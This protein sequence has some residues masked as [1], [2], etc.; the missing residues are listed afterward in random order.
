MLQFYIFT[1]WVRQYENERHL[2]RFGM[3]LFMR[4]GD[5]IL[6]VDD[7]DFSTKLCIIVFVILN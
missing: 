2:Y 6:T 1:I 7:D 5:S 3:K 4:I